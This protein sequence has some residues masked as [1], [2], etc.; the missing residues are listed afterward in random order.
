MPLRVPWGAHGAEG[1]CFDV[2][3]L[4]RKAAEQPSGRIVDCGHC[5]AEERPGE[6]LAEML[7]FFQADGTR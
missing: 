2:V 3:A 6:G 4:W 7:D 1:R 5:V